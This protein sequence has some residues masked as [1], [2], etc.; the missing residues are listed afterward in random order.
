[1]KSMEEMGGVG[2]ISVDELGVVRGGADGLVGEDLNDSEGGFVSYHIYYLLYFIY[3]YFSLYCPYH[4]YFIPSLSN[5][6][7]NIILFIIIHLSSPSPRTAPTPPSSPPSSPPPS[8]CS[9]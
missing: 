6:T 3:S 9:A 5:S 8:P 2:V 4:G 1:M 7:I